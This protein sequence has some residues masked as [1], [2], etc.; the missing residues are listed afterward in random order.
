MHLNIRARLQELNKSEFIG[1][2][3]PYTNTKASI[4]RNNI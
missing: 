3:P 2:L 4:Q 1:L